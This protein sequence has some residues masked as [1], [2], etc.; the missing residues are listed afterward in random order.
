MKSTYELKLLCHNL[1]WH[2][3]I[4]VTPKVDGNYIVIVQMK[5]DKSFGYECNVASYKWELTNP[6]PI[7]RY[8]IFRPEDLD[9]M[10]PN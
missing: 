5:Q 2:K 8:A 10:K 3:N 7:S 9:N 4:G 1:T 6:Y